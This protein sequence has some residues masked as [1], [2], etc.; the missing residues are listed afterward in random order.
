MIRQARGQPGSDPTSSQGPAG[1]FPPRPLSVG[2]GGGVVS[3][4]VT[5]TIE[6]VLVRA[7][8][9]WHEGLVVPPPWACIHG[10][11]GGQ[12]HLRGRAAQLQR[13]RPARSS[14][15][16]WAAPRPPPPPPV[17]EPPSPALGRLRSP[18]GHRACW[19]GMAAHHSLRGDRGGVAARLTGGY[20]RL[21]RREGGKG[22]G[23]AVRHEMQACHGGVRVGV[24][25]A[26]EQGPQAAPRQGRRG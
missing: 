16:P 19:A 21:A 4:I 20:L 12:T 5:G 2:E 25:Q 3:G 7:Q 13:M 22:T 26:G 18:H 6:G 1:P 10:W 17:A 24:P 15:V 11:P 9:G 14:G 8:A 23:W